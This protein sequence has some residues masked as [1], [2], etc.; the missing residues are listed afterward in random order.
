MS[1]FLEMRRFPSKHTLYSVRRRTAGADRNK[2]R[3]IVMRQCDG[4]DHDDK[5]ATGKP[6]FTLLLTEE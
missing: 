5:E 4:S 6:L 1:L 2:G 3:E